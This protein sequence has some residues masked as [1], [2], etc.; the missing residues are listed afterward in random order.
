MELHIDFETQAEIDLTKQ[1]LENYCHAHRFKIMCMAW[2]IDDEPIQIWKF[3]EPFPFDLQCA[4]ADVAVFMAHNASFEL[5]VWNMIGVKK[6]GWPELKTEQ[7]FCNMVMGYNMALPGKLEKLAPAL[8]L[9]EEKDLKG[10]RVMLQ[11]SQPRQVIEGGCKACGGSGFDAPGACEVCGGD[12]NEVIFYTPEDSPEKFEILYKY[13]IQ[14]VEVER[15]AGKRMIQLSKKERELWILDQRINNRGILV[16]IPLVTRA[17]E[18]I[19]YEKN[20]LNDELRIVS[21]NAIST[22]NALGQMKD[23]LK[24]YHDLDVGDSLGKNDVSAFLRKKDLPKSARRV[25]EIRQE[26]GK[27]S[28][29]KLKAMILRAG[30]D[31]RVRQAF[32]YYG[33]YSTGRWAGRGLQLQNMTKASEISETD[34]DNIMKILGSKKS[35]KHIV[36]EIDMLYGNCMSVIS[37][38]MRSFLIA[39]PGK[40]FINGDWSSIEARIL[41]WLA[42]D[43]KT[44]NVFAGHGKIYEFEAAGIY[45][46]P[47]ENVT[48]P[49][50]QIGKVA[51]LALGYQGGV[52]A[53]QMMAKTY[54]V[55]VPDKQAEEIKVAWR[56]AHPAIV[57]YW[58]EVEGA[59]IN[60]V[61]TPGQVFPAGPQGRQVKFRVVGSFLWCQLPSGRALSYPYPKI[62]DVETPWGAL[63]EAVTYMSEDAYTKKWSRQKTYGGHFV[64]NITQGLARDVLAEAIPRIENKGYEINLHVHDEM[65]AEVDEDF[66]SVEEFEKLMCE[67]PTWAAGLPL[68]AEAWSGSRYRK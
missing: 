64:E 51:V 63:K 28:V 67:L 36:D 34:I 32:Q 11:L 2:C 7:T 6:Y 56:E 5:M 55:K 53:F 43:Q 57:S 26:A 17:I 66:G 19:E 9:K 50:R 14:D 54:G 38:C 22:Y 62:E 27:A 8:G 18:V 48:K 23:W 37:Q 47:I 59:A 60:A 13:C 24:I 16:N 12:G 15:Q 29:A 10:G 46:V 65:N 31:G 58:S 21:G 42:G 39:A 61:R 35:L 41:A 1:G 20:R 4:I 49:Q 30:P 40:K 25:L 68:A 45:K 44:L 52:G 3:G 33:A